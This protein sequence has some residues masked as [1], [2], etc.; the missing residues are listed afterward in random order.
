MSTCDGKTMWPIEPHTKAKHEILRRYL[1][2]WFAIMGRT[3]PEITYLDGFCGP[4][5]YLGGED[6]SPIIAL[7]IAIDLNN[8]GAI[9]AKIN[10]VFVEQD[11]ERVNQLNIEIDK[12][13]PSIPSHFRIFIYHN[14]FDNTLS[15]ILNQLNQASKIIEPIFAFVDPF[16]FKGAPYQLIKQLLSNVKTEI[17]INIMA[18]S[19]NRFIE[20]PNP[21]ITQQ[22]IDLF[23][24]PS[25]TQVIQG[26]G[27][28]ISR[29]REL[30]QDQLSRCAK[31]VRY[32]EMRDDNHRVIYYLFF[33]SNN[34]LGHVKMKNAFWEVS[35]SNHFSFSDATDPHQLVLFSEE[36]ESQLAQELS[37]HFAGKT[38]LVDEIITNYVEDQTSYTSKLARKALNLLEKEGIISVENKKSDGSNRRSGTFPLEALVN[39]R[40]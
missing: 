29:L 20:H 31:F 3:N 32:F 40:K 36:P 39:F 33:A 30:Y 22:I 4:G 21:Q 15:Q 6:G 34:R 38:V 10:F 9:Q 27:D 23:G 2:A 8:K 26:N 17:F 37:K 19:I 24:T 11:K 25:V 18:D 35:Q 5:C 1:G 28:R 16:G 7:K 13:R 14:Q 12:L